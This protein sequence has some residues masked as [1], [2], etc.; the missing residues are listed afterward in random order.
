[1]D[2]HQLANHEGQFGKP[3]SSDTETRDG[4]ELPAYRGDMVNAFA[5]DGVAREHDPQRMLAAYNA[6]A[7]TLNLVRAWTTGGYADLGNLATW[8]ADASTEAT[9]MAIFASAL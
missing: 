6:S 4:V 7:A 3:R 9:M 5:F 8:G 1:M 2:H